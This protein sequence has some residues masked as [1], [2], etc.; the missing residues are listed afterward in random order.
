MSHQAKQSKERN[1]E[2]HGR[3]SHTAVISP[4]MPASTM[5][6]FICKILDFC[7]IKIKVKIHFI[8]WGWGV[9]GVGEKDRKRQ[10]GGQRPVGLISPGWPLL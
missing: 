1:V 10:K 7:F 3:P 5:C 8:S 2:I 9:G 6:T 4:P